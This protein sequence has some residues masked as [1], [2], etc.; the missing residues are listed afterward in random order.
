MVLALLGACQGPTADSSGFSTTPVLTT[1]PAG[2][3]DDTATA[4]TTSSSGGRTSASAGSSSSGESG[5]GET[6]TV[7]DL[8]TMPDI[9][10]GKPVGCKGKI[11]LLFV[12]SRFG[13][14][15]YRQAQLI[16]A[17]PKFITTIESKFADFDY[18]IM[19]VDGDADWGSSYCTDNCPTL[20]CK[21]GEPCCAFDPCPN[22]PYPVYLGQPCCGAVDYPCGQLDLVTACDNAFGAGNVFPAG[23]YASNK[24]CPIDGDLR[25]MVK[26]QTDL[27]GT[28]ACVAQLG[29]SGGDNLG[30]ALTAAMQKNINDPGGCNRGFLRKDALLMLTFI[31]VNPDHGGGNPSSEGFAEDW[32]KAVLDAKQGDPASVVMLTFSNPDWEPYDEI[33]RMAKM[34]PYWMVDRSDVSD[35]GPAFE[36]ASSLVETACAGFVVPG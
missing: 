34:F 32:A 6:T 12:I 20:A 5:I 13:Y 1:T 36:E 15:K 16:D 8:G 26:G 14:M 11:D 9:G 4:D 33:L 29:T 17:F 22:C 10:D 30:Q 19:V 27:A 3:A 28:F 7:L 18:H 23:D 25:Y 21:V 2:S 35:Y 24:P 31:G